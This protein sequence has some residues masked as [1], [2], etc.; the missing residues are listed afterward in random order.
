MNN[1]RS[2]YYS[3]EGQTYSRRWVGQEFIVNGQA[4]SS[5]V[6]IVAI[7]KEDIANSAIP[8][9]HIYVSNGGERALWKTISSANIEV[10]YM[11]DELLCDQ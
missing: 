7:T 9:Y 10:E 3:L 11:I 1:V 6:K 4:S 8:C 5:N 2:L